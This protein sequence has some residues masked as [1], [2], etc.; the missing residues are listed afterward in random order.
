[1]TDSPFDPQKIYHFLR[2]HP[3]WSISYHEIPK[4]FWLLGYLPFIPRR[5]V[6]LHHHCRHLVVRIDCHRRPV[7]D[8]IAEIAAVIDENPYVQPEQLE[9]LG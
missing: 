6:E 1:M 2:D 9:Q 4:F 3:G 7:D 5:W 8:V